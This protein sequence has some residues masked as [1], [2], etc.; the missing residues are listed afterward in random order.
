MTVIFIS[1]LHF[2]SLFCTAQ[3]F[4]AKGGLLGGDDKLQGNIAL[5]S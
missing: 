4:S 3:G 1:A 2:I 5:R